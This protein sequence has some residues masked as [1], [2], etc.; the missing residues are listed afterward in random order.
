MED[1]DQKTRDCIIKFAKLIKRF[2]RGHDLLEDK[3]KSILEQEKCKK[4]ENES[5][6]EKEFKKLDYDVLITLFPLE[7]K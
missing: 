3:K 7:D 4:S 6:V 2:I 5:E 1:E